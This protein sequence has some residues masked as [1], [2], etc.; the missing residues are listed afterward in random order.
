MAK[1]A[2]FDLFWFLK[3]TCTKAAFPDD[4]AFM[5]RLLL[6]N[7]HTPEVIWFIISMSNRLSCCNWS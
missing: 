6:Q 5:D 3:H 1:A 4:G 7:T 2:S